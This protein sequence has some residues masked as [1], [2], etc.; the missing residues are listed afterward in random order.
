MSIKKILVFLFCFFYLLVNGQ[1]SLILNNDSIINDYEQNVALLYLEVQPA[2]NPSLIRDST[3]KHSIE[4]IEKRIHFLN[5]QT[6]FDFNSS[7]LNLTYI[8]AY[9]EKRKKLTAKMLNYGKFYFPIFEEKLIKHELPLEL[10]YL[11][12]V[13]SALNPI[14]RSRAG[15]VGLW[16]FMPQTGKMMGLEINSYVDQRKDPLLST[17]AACLYLKK[18]YAIYG[19]WNLALA[20]YN[21]GPGNVNKAIRRAG[22]ETDYWKVRP[23]LPKE[24]QNYIP[25]FTAV[26]YMMNYNYVA[27]QTFKELPFVYYDVDTIHVEERIDFKVLEEWLSYD[28]GKLSLLNPTYTQQIVPKNNKKNSLCLPSFLIG[29]FLNQQDSIYHY[30]AISINRNLSTSTVNG[31]KFYIIKQG[32]TIWDIAEKYN[33]I[34]VA[35]I[36][37]F[38]KNVDISN[39]KKGDKIIISLH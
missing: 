7:K 26:N 14:A 36:K 38:N 11:P 32:D 19:D 9:S 33:G 24:T 30:S 23:F 1:D 21:A 18:L 2:I 15:A 37:S 34:S 25:A 20:A 12:I 8:K 13:E 39:I 5:H 27:N 6:P 35:D 28:A 17:E 29:D 3:I 31:S 10:K 22:G 16:Q 4:E